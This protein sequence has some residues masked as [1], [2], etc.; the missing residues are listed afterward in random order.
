MKQQ[1][2]QGPVSITKTGAYEIAKKLKAKLKEQPYYVVKHNINCPVEF[3]DEKTAN[4]YAEDDPIGLYAPPMNGQKETR[5][6]KELA[7]EIYRMAVIRHVDKEGY[8]RY[9][10]AKHHWTVIVP[11]DDSINSKNG[12]IAYFR[13]AAPYAHLKG[14][15]EKDGKFYVKGTFISSLNDFVNNEWAALWNWGATV[16]I[17]KFNLKIVDEDAQGLNNGNLPTIMQDAVLGMV[18]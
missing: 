16:F 11:A 7:A 14:V 1:M 8:R 15:A 4:N 17:H 13:G 2:P 9:M 18:K 10:L 12:A 5:T 3:W 6:I